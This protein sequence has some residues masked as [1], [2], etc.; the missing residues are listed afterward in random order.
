LSGVV[1]ERLVTPGS[2]VTV[3]TPL[4]VVSDLSQLWAI[5]EVDEA[6]LKFLTLGDAAEVTVAAYPDRTFHGRVAAIGDTVN[7][8]TRRVTVRIVLSNDDRS[9]KPQMFATVRL[10]TGPQQQALLLPAAAVQKLDQQP[11]LFIEQQPGRF[12]HR[13]VTLGE[14]REGLVEILSGLAA[15]ERVA[16]SGT[17]LI[18]SKVVDPGSPE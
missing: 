15:D 5:A 7:P 13:K 2:A 8:E 6:L 17:F 12:V 4:F 18:K 14:E 11:V 3:G 16:V 9:L 1:L 10:A